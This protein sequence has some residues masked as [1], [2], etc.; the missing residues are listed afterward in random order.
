[1]QTSEN[2]IV[3]PLDVPNAGDARSWV[4]I[5]GG[6]VGMFKVG[7]ELFSVAGPE[8]VREISGAGHRVFL[9]LK[10]HDIPATAQRAM[11]A[12]AKTGAVFSTAHCAGGKEMLAAAVAGAGGSVGVLGV[13]VLTS[14]S[15][16]SSPMEDLVIERALLAREAG[17][18]GVVCSGREAEAVKKAAGPGFL[19]IC[20]AVRPA[21]HAGS[22]DQKRIVTP[23]LAVANGADF[24]VIGRP[25]RDAANPVEAVEKIM[26]EIEAAGKPACGPFTTGR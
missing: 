4:E 11:S 10:I 16:T 6:R 20:P 12:I 24:L 2:P 19:V 9:D 14:V 3:F 1:M 23:A 22:D 7:L 8:I 13:T 18:A 25:I 17:C 21:W 26:K 5:L 15:G